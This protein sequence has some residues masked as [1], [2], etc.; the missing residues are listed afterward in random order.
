MVH[1]VAPNTQSSW[2]YFELLYTNVTCY[3]KGK[4]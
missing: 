3:K 1:V 2:I 4:Y